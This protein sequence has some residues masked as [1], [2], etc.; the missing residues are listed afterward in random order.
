MANSISDVTVDISVEDVVNPAA[1]GGI[2]LYARPDSSSGEWGKPLP[3]A[4]AYSYDEAKK[5]ISKTDNEGGLMKARASLTF[6][7]LTPNKTT[8]KATLNAL[9]TNYTFTAN[10]YDIESNNKTIN[11]V[12]YP[13]RVKAITDNNGINIKL[14]SGHANIGVACVGSTKGKEVTVMLKDSSGNVI[15]SYIVTGDE[16]EYVILNAESV[17]SSEILTLCSTSDVGGTLHIYA[18][19]Q[20]YISDKGYIMLESVEKV[21]MQ[22]NPPEKIGLLSCAIDKITDYLSCDWRYL[23]EIGEDDKISEIAKKIEN[24]GA[25]KVLGIKTAIYIVGISG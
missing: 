16:A 13:L 20:L 18:I 1:F 14:E 8:P 25:N 21:F 11:G 2:S 9:N 4:E 7:T 22:D 15:D 19:E 6:K 12:S 5:I 17:S 10:T 23:I 3:Y 24:F